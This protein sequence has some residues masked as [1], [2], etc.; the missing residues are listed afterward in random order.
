MASLG[1]S[2]SL[3]VLK[4][5]LLRR[6]GSALARPWS[7]GRKA[8]LFMCKMKLKTYMGYVYI[9][10]RYIDYLFAFKLMTFFM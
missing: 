10:P 5:G 8:K 6:L 7:N 4:P 1:A 3:Q 9:C 2:S